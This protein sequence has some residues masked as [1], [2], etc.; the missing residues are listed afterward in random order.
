M[1]RKGGRERG[2][3]FIGVILSAVGP[4]GGRTRLQSGSGHGTGEASAKGVLLVSIDW[5]HALARHE[6][7]PNFTNSSFCQLFSSSLP[8]FLL[9]SLS[10]SPQLY[11]SYSFCRRRRPVVVYEEEERGEDTCSGSP[12]MNYFLGTGHHGKWRNPRSRILE[13]FPSQNLSQP[14]PLNPAPAVMIPPH[15]VLYPIILHST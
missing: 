14:G 10:A 12:L 9:P 7:A 6:A 13:L 15:S 11:P 8:T 5:G 1:G 3:R 4:G 2:R